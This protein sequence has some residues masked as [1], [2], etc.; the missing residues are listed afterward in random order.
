MLLL[1]ILIIFLFYKLEEKKL[2][3][4]N[5]I[6]YTGIVQHICENYPK[7]YQVTLLIYFW[8]KWLLYCFIEKI[9]QI[10]EIL[11]KMTENSLFSM[12]ILCLIEKIY[13]FKHECVKIMNSTKYKTMKN[14]SN[15]VKDEMNN[16]IIKKANM[17]MKNIQGV[18]IQEFEIKN[19]GNVVCIENENYKVLI[20]SEEYLS[21]N[22]L[23]IEKVYLEKNDR[24]I[25]ITQNPRNKNYPC[26][27]D[28]YG[29]SIIV[30]I[31]GKTFKKFSKFEKPRF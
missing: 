8:F 7:I 10:F 22:D 4:T 30:N 16:F 18:D 11:F 3:I 19:I 31:N 14:I 26:A 1:T 6:E 25:D 12:I 9:C 13:I 15:F 2:M 17:F 27:F 5:F 23:F 21:E 28:M 24:L 29:D 20:P